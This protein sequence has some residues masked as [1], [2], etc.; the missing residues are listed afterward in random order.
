MYM[1]TIEKFKTLISQSIKKKNL[2]NYGMLC[3]REIKIMCMTIYFMILFG[4]L[5]VDY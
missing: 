4:Y 2:K 1:N 3:G 5:T